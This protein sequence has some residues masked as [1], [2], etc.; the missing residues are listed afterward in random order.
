MRGDRK[1]VKS[2]A[3]QARELRLRKSEDAPGPLGSA[4]AF[5]WLADLYWRAWKTEERES[6]QVPADIDKTMDQVQ[7]LCQEAIRSLGLAG[8]QH[9]AW[10]R[11]LAPVEGSRDER[12]MDDLRQIL[13]RYFDAHDLVVLG[14]DLLGAQ[15]R[16][17]QDRITA[18][19]LIGMCQRRGRIPELVEKC[20]RGRPE[21]RADLFQV[22]N[23]LSSPPTPSASAG[24]V[25][26]VAYYLYGLASQTVNRM[27]EAGDSYLEAQKLFEQAPTCAQQTLDIE[28]TTIYS[29]A[30][31]WIERLISYVYGLPKQK[32]AEGP[33][34]IKLIYPWRTGLQNTYA[35]AELSLVRFMTVRELRRQNAA[36]FLSDRRQAWRQVGGAQIDG[37]QVEQS[38][39]LWNGDEGAEFALGELNSAARYNKGLILP[40][41]ALYQTV[42]AG[43]QG[44]QSHSGVE[45]GDY[46]LACG[47]ARFDPDVL[48]TWWN[49]RDEQA[50]LAF[51]RDSGGRIFPREGI[52]VRYVGEKG[53]RLAF[54]GSA[55]FTLRARPLVTSSGK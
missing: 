45:P 48:S 50:I 54:L 10:P 16:R 1:Q 21:A 27:Q 15:I 13:D 51:G 34:G 9:Y 37:Y 20:A 4:I 38:L 40:A 53:M 36:K 12:W 35:L 32:G 2:A 42:P 26:A 28:R 7:D 3:R 46:L 11:G 22:L 52:P 43:D 41:G 49:E 23:A 33:Q 19:R 5:L 17:E 31:D 25:K 24:M 30:C 47:T 55:D 18:V 29:E 44:A 8:V 39:R 6:D 14:S